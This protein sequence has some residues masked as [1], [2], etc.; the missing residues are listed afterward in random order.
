M[1]SATIGSDTRQSRIA[2]LDW[3]AMRASIDERGYA[4]TPA[5]LTP[6]ECRELIVLYDGREAF[7]NRVV[8]ERFG[9]GLG[10]YK[11]FAAPLPPLVFAM[12]NA[13]YARLAPIASTW[14]RALG[15]GEGFPAELE[16]FLEI[17][18]RAGQLK[19]TPLMLR[20]EAGGYNC[21][22]QD[23]YGEV[24]FPLQM[25]LALSRR[26]E[27]FDGGEFL[28]TEQ[29]PRAQSRGEAITL[30]RGEAIIFATRWRPV[31]GK[32][33]YYRVNVRHGVSRLKAGRRFTL[34]IIFHD[35]K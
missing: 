5:L 11:Y 28:L 18:R 4:T 35:A 14:M 7:R 22:H 9:Y 33:G 3:D 25:T 13:F 26:G 17:C 23:L 24:F 34:G 10:E 19:P 2:R 15:L 1:I 31:R 20:Y 8:M 27:E 29:R 32:R 30:E 16:A 21:L 12:R 6:A